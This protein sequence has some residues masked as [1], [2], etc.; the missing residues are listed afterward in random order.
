MS[1]RSQRNPKRSGQAKVGQ[2]QIALPVDQ[3]VLRLQVPM[4]DAMAVT[5]TDPF[6]QLGHELLDHCLP[7]AH[8]HVH[9]RATGQSFP[10]TAF[11]HGQRV[12]IPFQVQVQELKDQVQ[13]AALCVDNVQKTNDGRV[14]HFLQERDFADRCAGNALVVRFQSDL[15]QRHYAVWMVE[16]ASLV[17]NPVRPYRERERLSASMD[18]LTTWP[19]VRTFSDFL[20]LLVVLH[21]GMN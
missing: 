6:Y 16:F 5:E 12:H 13:L 15:F 17:D 11:A 8:V 18:I 2:L 21:G 4:Q 9:Y 20:D 19:R 3:Q 14:F 10:S 7:H 1:I